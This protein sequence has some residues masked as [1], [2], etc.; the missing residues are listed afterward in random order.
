VRSPPGQAGRCRGSIRDGLANPR[1]T[2]A[3]HLTPARP[4]P[5]LARP[6]ALPGTVNTGPAIAAWPPAA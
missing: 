1:I 6:P 2:A 4:D 5:G 3:G